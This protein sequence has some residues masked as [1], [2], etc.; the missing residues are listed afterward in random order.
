M[1]TVGMSGD[2]KNLIKD[3][4]EYIKNC[5]TLKNYLACD[6]PKDDSPNE[7]AIKIQF[8]VK[9]LPP[10]YDITTSIINVLETIKSL[11]SEF[12]KRIKSNGHSRR[13]SS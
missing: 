11:I 3:F 4:K 8:P 9:V 6:Y 10:T 5:P 7:C 13:P 2:L 1:T 12:S